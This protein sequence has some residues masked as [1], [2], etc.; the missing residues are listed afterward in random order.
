MR[1]EKRIGKRIG[2]WVDGRGETSTKRG[3]MRQARYAAGSRTEKL[4]QHI[5]PEE[6]LKTQPH[7][8][9]VLSGVYA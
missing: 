9:W 1:I 5:V 4:T 3:A 2:A 7:Q 8:E 6:H